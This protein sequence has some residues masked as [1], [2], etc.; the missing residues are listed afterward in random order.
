MSVTSVPISFVIGSRKMLTVHRLLQTCT[1]GIDD[2]VGGHLPQLPLPDPSADGLRVLSAPYGQFEAIRASWPD[3]LVGGFQRYQRYYIEMAGRSYED[4]LL[5]FSSKTRAT[6]RRKSRKLEEYC[7]GSLDI[8]A[9][10][11]EADVAAF[12]ADAVPLSRKTYQTRLLNVGLPEGDDA[13]ASMKTLARKD[14]L[15]AYILYAHGQAISYLYLPTTG[16]VVTYAYLG[17][18]P[19]HAHLSVGTVLQMHVLERLFGE[20]RYRYFDFTEGEG[21][22]KEMFGT[23][24]IDACSFFLI[25]PGPANRMLIGGLK[26]FDGGVR[27]I[28]RLAQGSGALARVRQFLRK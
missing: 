5:Q 11:G 19:G 16:G 9:F 15:R 23:A 27:L 21:A 26:A 22:H 20:G 7:G 14:E 24:S 25:K 12:L 13:V 10:H 3:H 6:L 17:Y 8:R 4:Y 1:F 18:D 2:L 28:K